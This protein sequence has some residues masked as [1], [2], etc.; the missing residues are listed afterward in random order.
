MAI[1][2]SWPADCLGPCPANWTLLSSQ[3]MTSSWEVR[4]GI[5]DKPNPVHPAQSLTLFSIAFRAQVIPQ[6]QLTFAELRL[7]LGR[8][9]VEVGGRFKLPNRCLD[10]P[11][12][13]S[14]PVVLGGRLKA[15]GAA[16]L[17]HLCKADCLQLW[18][19]QMGAQSDLHD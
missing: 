9:L 8:G 11:S 15:C 12:L 5:I 1:E 10:E 17:G 3:T 4:A 14:P 13:Q 16:A 7:G 2:E 19:A 18:R 6:P